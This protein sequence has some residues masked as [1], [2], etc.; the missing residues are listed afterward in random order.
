MV[1]DLL[2]AGRGVAPD[3][4]R[5]DGLLRRSGGR[6]GIQP[7]PPVDAAGLAAHRRPAALA[8]LR[9][10]RSSPPSDPL[11]PMLYGDL[12]EKHAPSLVVAS[13]PGWRLDRYLLREAAQRGCARLR[14]SSVGTIPSSYS[15]PARRWIQMTCWSQHSEAGAGRGSD[16]PPERVHV[17]GIPSTTATSAPLAAAPAWSTSRSTGSIPTQLLIAYACSFISFSPKSRTWKRWPGWLPKI[18]WISRPSCWSGCTPTISSTCSLRAERERIRRLACDAATGP[19]R[20][21]GAAGRRAR[22]LLGGRH[23]R[24]DID[25]GPRRCLPDG[26]LHHGRRG[27]HP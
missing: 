19:R 27:R 12:F 9:R 7:P 26:V 4:H 17:G 25:D 15:L 21:A 5:G 22:A 16:W 1:A 6:R 24:E 3:Q 20:R 18:G 2:S 11:R 10:R 13:T 23:A 8:R 14:S